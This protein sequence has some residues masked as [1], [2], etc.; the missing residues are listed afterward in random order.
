MDS[1][2][3]AICWP[4]DCHQLG[5]GTACLTLR[6]EITIDWDSDLD[7][8]LAVLLLEVPQVGLED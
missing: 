8:S 5:S 4:A 1:W 3:C 6:E 2:L 7:P